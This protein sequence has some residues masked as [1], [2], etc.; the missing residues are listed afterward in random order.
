MACV[1]SSCSQD[2]GLT[3]VREDKSIFTGSI[4]LVESRISLD[5]VNK[6]SWVQ[7]DELSIFKK[8]NLNSRFVV[9]NINNGSATFTELEDDNYEGPENIVSLSDNYAVYP[10][11]VVNSIDATGTIT[12]PVKAGYTFKDRESFISSALMAAKSEGSRLSFKHVHGFLRLR[13]CAEIPE[14]YTPIQSVTLTSKNNKMT[15]TTAITWKDGLP[16]AAI[17]ADGAGQSVTVN[18]DGEFILP[19]KE[20][21]EYVELY[22]PVLPMEFVAND[23]TMVVTFTNKNTYTKVFG[24]P[25]SIVRREVTGLK[26]TIGVSDFMGD[27]EGAEGL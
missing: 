10:Y 8:N 17:V 26:H 20:S 4:E 18:M 19:S 25:F 7:N 27:L 5:K 6:I 1:L 11:S 14:D 3:I 13:L 15:G 2:D 23:M 21:G 24:K 22:V 9:S 16:S 12:V